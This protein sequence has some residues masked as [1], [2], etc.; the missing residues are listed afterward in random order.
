MFDDDVHGA[1]IGEPDA[2]YGADLHP[3]HFY[4]RPFDEVR[5]RI[6]S[7]YLIWDAMAG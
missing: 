7:I 3:V 2:A 6:V 4:W 1:W 5:N